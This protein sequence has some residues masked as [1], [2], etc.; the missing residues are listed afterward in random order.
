MIITVKTEQNSP[1]GSPENREHLVLEYSFSLVADRPACGTGGP[2][3]IISK[4]PKVYR[5]EISYN[6]GVRIRVLGVILTQYNIG[7]SNTI[8]YK[9]LSEV[10]QI[11]ALVEIAY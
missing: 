11:L 6:T 3:L 10:Q 8:T 4:N 7:T 2:G 1:R 5:V 9:K